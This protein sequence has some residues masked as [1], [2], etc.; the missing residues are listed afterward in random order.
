MK[1]INHWISQSDQR[2]IIGISGHG[3][4]GK[5]TFAKELIKQLNDV[6]YM[7][8]DPYIVSSEVR[9]NTMINYTY[10]SKNYRY[11]MTA[12]HPS[13]HHLPSLE[14]DVRM[15]RNGLDLFTI[16]THYAE[17]VLLSSNSR[18]TIIEGMSVAFIDPNLFDLK[19]YFYTDEETEFL[20]RSARDVKE[21]GLDINYLKASHEQRRIQYE[22]FMHPFSHSFDVIVKTSQGEQIVE[23]NA[24]KL[25]EM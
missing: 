3:A 23:K 2:I 6:N 17:S 11:K 16:D 13:A 19:L 12:C 5:T 9:R 20:R 1:E 15:V 4:A 25:G 10:Y 22:V 24:L 7:N 18:V 21:R 8:T 14:R